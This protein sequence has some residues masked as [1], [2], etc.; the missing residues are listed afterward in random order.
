MTKIYLLGEFKVIEGN[1]E[2][3]NNIIND[4]AK[5]AVLETLI[6]NIDTPV[7]I[8][9]LTKNI[10]A[11][12]IG[13]KGRRHTIEVL[14]A[15]K[16]DLSTE[17][18][19]DCFVLT[20]KTCEWKSSEDVVLD[21][22]VLKNLCNDIAQ[23]EELDTDFI[24]IAEEII[25]MYSGELLQRSPNSELFKE[26]R[27]ETREIYSNAIK[28][29]ISLLITAERYFDVSRVCKIALEFQPLDKFLI[30]SFL[31]ALAKI[32]KEKDALSYYHNIVSLYEKYLGI[33]PPEEIL[34]FYSKLM[35]NEHTKEID[36]DDLYRDLC[37]VSSPVHEEKILVCD[38]SIFKDVYNLNVRNFKRLNI[39]MYLALLTMRTIGGENQVFESEKAMQRLLSVLKNNLR[40]G[41]TVSRY[42]AMRYVVLLP[43]QDSS[44]EV[45][46]VLER[47][48]HAFY[49][50][51]SNA[52][53]SLEYK[54]LPVDLNTVANKFSF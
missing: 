10:F 3:I 38:I 42:D 15:L 12:E 9:Q 35:K 19:A 11:D 52:L 33:E 23:K 41:D 37:T 30:V 29:Y 54:I 44:S 27:G 51:A 5:S 6:I 25:L 13:E 7:E 22:D 18:F 31:T 49:K 28:N 48:K 21:I 1:K 34:E 36:I 40:R 2:L 46:V 14:N 53:F 24:N 43:K 47:I 8:E 4:K 39:S 26:K 17:K 16:Q 45:R 50:D 32:N 20:G